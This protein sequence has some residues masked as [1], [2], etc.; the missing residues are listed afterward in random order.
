[1]T[2][3][4]AHAGATIA[5]SERVCEC[6]RGC[7]AFA[8]VGRGGDDSVGE[9][10]RNEALQMLAWTMA[11]EAPGRLTLQE[12]PEP[13]PLPHEALV[14]VEAFAPN[15]G[16]IAALAD[17]PRGR[18]PGW[19]GSGV[20]LEPAADGRGP[21]RGERVVFLGLAAAGWAQRRAVP[22]AMTAAAPRDAPWDRL[23]ALPVPATSALRAVRRLGSIVGRR[24]LIVGG[25]S[26]VGRFAIQLAARS[27]AS[28]VAVARD[29]GQHA[30][31]H[32]LGAS[33]THASLTTVSRPVH[34]AIDVLGGQHLVVAYSLL[35][36]GGMVIA[37]GHAAGADE[38]FPF[39]A[40]VADPST[41]DRAITSFFLGTEPNL[42]VEM[43]YLAA[44][45]SL[46][47]GNIDLRSWTSLAAWVAAGAERP[48]GRRIVFRVDHDDAAG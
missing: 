30:A 4:T 46:D 5:E 1:M 2:I 27:G 15:P 40:F 20:V 47:V 28:V 6:C 39:G 14:R 19:D 29:E 13:A 33:E 48:S 12:M 35:E 25:T 8:L 10:D 26:A 17:M 44:D 11:P 16:D 45:R 38:H 9:D 7:H 23:A 32:A 41:S 31:L 22:H 42:D 34:G 37:L 18:I 43:A 3:G 24:V 36:Q 21:Q